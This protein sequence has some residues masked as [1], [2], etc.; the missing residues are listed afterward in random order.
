MRTNNFMK[1]IDLNKS[2]FE[3]AQKDLFGII[4]K[5]INDEELK[6][7]L[8]Y[9]GKDAL[10][11]PKL[12][13]AETMS[14]VHD[15]IKIVPKIPVD[16]EVKSQIIVSFDNYTTNATN[17]EFRDNIITFDVLCPIDIWVLEG[18][19]LRPYKIMGEIDGLFNKQKLNGIGMVEFIS[20]NQL[21]LNEEMAGFTL[22]Y[23]VVNDV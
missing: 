18:Y 9:N 16:D 5:L 22:M 21:L 12:T 1:K 8:F 3:S 13:E 2:T 11:Q 14:L 10:R 6:K 15:R 7:L 23:R 20:A 17:P 4:N 19:N